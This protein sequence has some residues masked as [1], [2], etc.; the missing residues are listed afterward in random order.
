MSVAAE[1][2]IRPT[3]ES[4]KSYGSAFPWMGN[5][6]PPRTEDGRFNRRALRYKRR[7]TPQSSFMILAAIDE[8][9][10]EELRRLLASMTDAPGCAN[11]QNDLMAFGRF[12]TL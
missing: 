12:E 1:C 5:R 4:K 9:R 2:G 8:R 10:Q 6:G 11:P 3:G 7:M